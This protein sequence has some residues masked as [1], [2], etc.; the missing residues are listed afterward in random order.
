MSKSG[1]IPHLTLEKKALNKRFFSILFCFLLT[2]NIFLVNF[3]N[4]GLKNVYGMLKNMLNNS[5][6][7]SRIFLMVSSM[8]SLTF[9]SFS[10]IF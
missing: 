3:F 2:K 6:Y 4:I 9:L 1:E 5:I 8:I 10:I 7:L